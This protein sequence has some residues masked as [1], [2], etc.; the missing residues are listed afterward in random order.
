MS[1]WKFTWYLL[2]ENGKKSVIFVTK[3]NLVPKIVQ[4]KTSYYSQSFQTHVN[5][6]FNCSYTNICCNR[7]FFFSFHAANV[8]FC[9]LMTSSNDERQSA[10]FCCSARQGHNNGHCNMSF[11]RKLVCLTPS[12]N[13][14]KYLLRLI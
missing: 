1:L 5:P 13:F 12:S 6:I 9:F 10:I 8:A 14:K 4:K 11:F 7:P 3:W 2:L